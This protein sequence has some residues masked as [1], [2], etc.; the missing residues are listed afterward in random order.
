MTVS[1][2]DHSLTPGSL[3]G[4]G[5]LNFKYEGNSITDNLFLLIHY[6]YCLQNFT[7]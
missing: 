7:K 4:K 3:P 2:V 5:F 1:L 6:L